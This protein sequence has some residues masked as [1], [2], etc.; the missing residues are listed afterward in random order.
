MH[1][2]YNT[3]HIQI[4]LISSDIH[5]NLFVAYP[6]PDKQNLIGSPVSVNISLYRVAVHGMQLIFFL[7]FYRLHLS[8]LP[9]IYLVLA[10]LALL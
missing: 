5:G 6:I 7:A 8:I 3:S 4:G 9:L 2:L 1:V 10:H